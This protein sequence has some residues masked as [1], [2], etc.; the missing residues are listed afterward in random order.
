MYEDDET[1]EVE[2]EL[3][4]RQEWLRN[5]HTKRLLTEINDRRIEAERA[6]RMATQGDTATHD[7]LIRLGSYAS[8]FDAI[9]IYLGVRKAP[10][11]KKRDPIAAKAASTT[12]GR[13]REQST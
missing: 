10:V 5:P 8:A 1:H 4:D 7:M 6:L 11:V 3:D 13:M 12:I 2:E 9:L